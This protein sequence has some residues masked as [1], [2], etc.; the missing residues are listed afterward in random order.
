M[1]AI[2]FP[3]QYRYLPHNRLIN[4][5]LRSLHILSFAVLVGGHYF[6]QP[7]IELMPWFQA[8]LV[9][10]GLM[11]LIELYGSFTFLIE[12]RGLSVLLKLA[13]LGAIPWFWDSRFLLLAT[14]VILASYTSHMQGKYRH[15]SLISPAVIAR[16]R[17][18]KG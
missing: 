18:G 2:L 5:T 10:G 14:V 3:A 16:L 12:L 8:A 4:L 9:T 11:V 15:M 6:D 17:E 7:V 13:I 1:I